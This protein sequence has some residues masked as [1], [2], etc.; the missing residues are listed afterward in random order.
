MKSKEY[1]FLC[2]GKDCKRNGSKELYRD[3]PELLKKKN[4]RSK[5]RVIKTK[6]M[7]HCKKGPNVIHANRLYSKVNRR[8]L[9]DIISESFLTGRD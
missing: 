7:D 2:T 3:L 9:N 6:C 4:I 8:F 1:I 5:V